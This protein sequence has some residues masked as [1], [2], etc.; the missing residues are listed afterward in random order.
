MPLLKSIIGALVPYKTLVA[1]I[2]K[3]SAIAV[4]DARTAELIEIY[5]DEN[6]VAPWLSE[7]TVFGEYLYLGSW[8]NNYLAR[9]KVVHL[10]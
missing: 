7:A 8:F 5:R 2:P 9:V 10:K 6:N 1:A 4:F 3:F